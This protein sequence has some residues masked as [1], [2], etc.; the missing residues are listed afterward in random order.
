MDE[1]EKILE[2]YRIYAAELYSFEDRAQVTSRLYVTINSAVIS[3]V[4]Y[5]FTQEGAVTVQPAFSA[6]LAACAIAFCLIWWLT[7]RSITR[8]TTA[9]HEVL[10]D[11]EA[12]L[13]A[14]PYRD[15]WFEKLDQGKGYVRT[16]LLHELFPWVFL[17]AYVALAVYALLA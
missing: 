12:R 6:A 14:Q 10:Q 9:K 4:V 15:E 11:L 2:Q 3:A 7:L 13:P 16:T 17:V 1:Q 5:G 8:H